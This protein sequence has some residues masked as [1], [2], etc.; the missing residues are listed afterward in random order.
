M[1]AFHVP[2]PNAAICSRDP[3][4]K[5][6]VH[7]ALVVASLGRSVGSGVASGN[8]HSHLSSLKISL[9][10]TGEVDEAQFV[11]SGLC[12]ACKPRPCDGCVLGEREN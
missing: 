3:R 5:A 12:N 7:R 9:S 2:S 6:G 11:D 10:F 8:F 1:V 4:S